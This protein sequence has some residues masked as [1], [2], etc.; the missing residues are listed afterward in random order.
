MK[1]K[2][3]SPKVLN[4]VL[5][6]VILLIFVLTIGTRTNAEVLTDNASEVIPLSRE[7]NY[8]INILNNKLLEPDESDIEITSEESESE[9]IFNLDYYINEYI[10]T[11]KFF[12][13]LFDYNYE[14]II[15]DLKNKELEN[16]DFEYTNIG[17][18]KNSN[19]DLEKY[20]NFEYGLIEYFYQLNKDKN[21]KR[22]VTYRPYKG[23]AKY[24]EDL[25]QYFSEIY[26]NVDKISLL[27]IGAAES[28][29]YKV[30][31]MLKYNNVYGGMSN[32]K[33]I[34]HNNIEQGTLSFVRLMSRNYYGK[35]LNTLESIGRVY[36]PVIENGIK[37]ASPHWKNLVTKARN[38][39]NDYTDTITIEDL[40]NREEI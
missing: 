1:S 38:E 25:I 28:G 14:D 36:C 7:I 33:L 4:I 9:I 16:Y 31:Y 37:K 30:K 26:S 18:L 40:I 8:S 12:S 39:Y 27:S 23:N 34:K 32:K 3:S 13:E 2:V 6:V 19:N 21:I 29:Y 15:K 35:G 17:Y 5:C 22:E 10:I 11:I 24:V 20:A